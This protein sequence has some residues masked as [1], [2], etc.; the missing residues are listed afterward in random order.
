[1][2]NLYLPILSVSM[3]FVIL[4]FKRNLFIN[5]QEL[6]QFNYMYMLVKI[7]F[8][9]HTKYTYPSAIIESILQSVTLPTNRVLA[10]S[11][12]RSRKS[13]LQKLPVCSQSEEFGEKTTL[14]CQYFRAVE[15]GIYT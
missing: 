10:W 2:L 15:S 13:E 1:M 11:S 4:I 9:N 7:R 12:G 14:K 5:R 8:N 6:Y 3:Q